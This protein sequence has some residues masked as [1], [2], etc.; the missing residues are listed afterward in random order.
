MAEPVRL[1]PTDRRLIDW[2]KRRTDARDSRRI[3][4]EGA[5][6]VDEALRLEHPLEVVWVTPDALHKHR[7]LCRSAQKVA[8]RFS[9]VGEAAMRKVSD[10]E[11][12][13]GIAAVAPEPVFRFRRPGDPLNLILAVA[14]VQDPGNL[15]TIIRTADFFGVDEVWLGPGSAD[16]LAPKV[17]RGSMGASLR[18]PVRRVSDLVGEVRAFKEA[19]VR[20]WAAVPRGGCASL[21]DIETL[22]PRILMVGAESRGLNERELSVAEGTVTISG[23][24]RAESLNQAVAAGILIFLACGGAAGIIKSGE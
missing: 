23:V 14:M 19:S 21:R 20:V 5:K 9:V 6:L 7:A 15:G 13:P 24:G 11:T 4:L 1:T 18:M 3:L 10:L 8:L 2:A 12:P 16:P 17:I 22:E